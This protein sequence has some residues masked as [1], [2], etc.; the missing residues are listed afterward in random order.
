MTARPRVPMMNHFRRP[1]LLGAM[2]LFAFFVRLI[3]ALVWEWYFG[4]RFVFGDSEGYWWLARSLAHGEPYQFGDFGVVFRMPGYPALLA[5]LFWI[6]DSP[7][8]LAARIEGSLFGAMTVLATAWWAGRLFGGRAELLAGLIMTFHPEMVLSSILVLS[9]AAFLPVWTAHLGILSAVMSPNA[10][11]DGHKRLGWG[12]AV[13]GLAGFATLIRPVALLWLPFFA[14][15]MLLLSPKRR[16]FLVFG[17]I[18]FLGFVIVMSPWWV[19]NYWATGRWI[20][21]TTQTGPT[22]YDGLHPQATGASNMDFVPRKLS[23]LRQAMAGASNVDVEIEF[24]RR[25]TI[26]AFRWAYYHPR[27]TTRLARIKFCRLWNLCPNDPGFNVFPVNAI[28]AVSFVC[29]IILGLAGVIRLRTTGW[30]GV[31]CWLPTVYVTLLHLLLVASIRYR[32][33]ALPGL[34]VLGAGFLAAV[35]E[36]RSIDEEKQE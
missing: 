34:A 24:N 33:P 19:R 16:Q 30:S 23:E 15:M 25:L 29:V 1:L 7:P 10:L 12:L 8:R 31:L 18:S 4:P 14:G 11:G 32:W 6:F 36:K 20:L 22:L 3:A 13:G 35:I 9:E 26:E 5:P 27:E 17:I 2:F 28:V 21:T